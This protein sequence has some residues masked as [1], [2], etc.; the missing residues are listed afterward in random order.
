MRPILWLWSLPLTAAPTLA[1]G[2]DPEP[3]SPEELLANLVLFLVT[4]GVAAAFSGRVLGPMFADASRRQELVG[5]GALVAGL[6]LGVSWW[7]ARQTVAEAFLAKPTPPQHDIHFLASGG[8]VA[9]WG[10]YH[11]EVSRFRS[12]EFRLFVSDA[13]RRPISTHHYRATIAPR[14]EKTGVPGP[15]LR[16]MEESA[17]KDYLFALLEP[18][19]RSVQLEVAVPGRKVRLNFLFDETAGKRSRPIECGAT[20]R[21]ALGVDSS[22]PKTPAGSGSPAR[23]E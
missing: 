10:D 15:P 23:S 14:D 21:G 16:S 17:G 19:D 7:L 11:A 8:Q 20:G 3:S 6:M 1:H 22:R 4:L 2:N 12:G 5:W 18:G 9:M 13:Y